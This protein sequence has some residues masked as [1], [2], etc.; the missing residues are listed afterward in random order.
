MFLMAS[1]N[2][3]VGAAA[4][5]LEKQ[6][7]GP[8]L[9]SPAPARPTDKHPSWRNLVMSPWV[10]TDAA[11][12]AGALPNPVG[13]EAG[14]LFVTAAAL[15]G[16]R[17]YLKPKK[18]APT[19]AHARAARE[20]IAS[21][22]ASDLGVRVPPVVLY[23]RPNPG[24]DEE[25][26]CVSLVLYPRQ[27]PWE[28]VRIAIMDGKPPEVLNTV[29]P[30]MPKSAAQG[31]ALDTW[32]EQL[33]H[34]GS[35]GKR[36]HPHN[37]VYGYEPG[38][39]PSGEFVFLDFAFSLGFPTPDNP[40]GWGKKGWKRRQVAP[41]FPAY[42]LRFIDPDELDRVTSRIEAYSDQDIMD[43][44]TRVPETHLVKEQQSLIIEGLVERKKLVRSLL[45]EHLKK[46]TS[47]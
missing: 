22:L 23:S 1:D 31:L 20:K 43:V 38:S 32:L 21:D 13:G 11:N 28:Q 29:K 10:W 12:Q 9:A 15:G 30:G 4:P 47:K 19:P 14:G 5:T 24:T 17:A 33:D 7:P 8:G 27:W 41:A 34:G 26:T 16:R 37:I 44:V 6:T 42:M 2:G 40:D 35:D 45:N 39:A 3:G 25:H 18:L 36:G 46:G